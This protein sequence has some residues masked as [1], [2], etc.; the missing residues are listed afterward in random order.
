METNTHY[1]NKVPC[2]VAGEA[3]SPDLAA[4]VVP[5]M[6]LVIS[7]SFVQRELQDK[8]DWSSLSLCTLLRHYAL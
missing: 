6:S 7:G 3:T 1:V 8:V 5:I 4:L 2:R